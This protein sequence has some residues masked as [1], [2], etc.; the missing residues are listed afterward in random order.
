MRFTELPIKGAYEIEPV[1]EEDNRG[2]FART[3]CRREFSARGLNP[4]IAQ[5]STSFNRLKGTLRGMHYQMAP[6]TECKLVQCLAG[7]TFHVIVDLR[8]N[9]G[10]Y[11]EWTSVRLNA[12][13]KNMLYVPEGLAHGFLTLEDNCEVHYQISE[14]YCP[15]R[16]AGI[17]W[18][19]PAIGIVWPG[20]V[21]VISD[22]DRNFPAF[23]KGL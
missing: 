4:D 17:R 5:C 2:F 8:E 16:A 15:D 12:T 9:A 1:P 21:A 3:F 22:R 23:G 20:E 11:L 6:N 7:S 18:N 10:T 19:D 14:F 13:R